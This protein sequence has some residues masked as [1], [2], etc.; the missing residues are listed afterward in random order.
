MCKLLAFHDMDGSEEGP[1]PIPPQGQQSGLTNIFNIFFIYSGQNIGATV[2][3]VVEK[4]IKTRLS[5]EKMKKKL[6][7]AKP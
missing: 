2:A 1:N 6:L 5:E 4:V 7:D 3:T